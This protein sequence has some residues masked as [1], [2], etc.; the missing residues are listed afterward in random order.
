MITGDVKLQKGQLLKANVRV[1]INS[2]SSTEL[3]QATLPPPPNH[4]PI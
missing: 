3:N 1:A 4:T 2:P